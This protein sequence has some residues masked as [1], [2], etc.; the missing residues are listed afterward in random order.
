MLTQGKRHLSYLDTLMSNTRTYTQAYTQLSPLTDRSQPKGDANANAHTLWGLMST[1][2]P[3]TERAE[4]GE[5]LTWGNN[6]S[7]KEYYKHILL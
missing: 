3:K 1:V 7:D 4:T 6:N 5:K 2:R